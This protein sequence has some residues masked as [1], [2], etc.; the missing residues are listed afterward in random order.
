[1]SGI[2]QLWSRV[3]AESA[4]LQRRL[5]LLG[6]SEPEIEAVLEETLI[7]VL[8][9]ARDSD[10]E[11]LPVTMYGTAVRVAVARRDGGSGLD[12]PQTAG[13][14]GARAIGAREIAALGQIPF[15]QRVAVVGVHV[16]GYTVEEVAEALGTT[17]E[18]VGDLVQAGGIALAD[19]LRGDDAE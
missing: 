16:S 10:A 14:W 2:A 7:R 8:A 13:G 1:M 5:R 6:L 15:R 12:G 4:V 11:L 9:A 17:P 3:K 18:E 19:A